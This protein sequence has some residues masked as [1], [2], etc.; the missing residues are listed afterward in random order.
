MGQSYRV[1]IGNSVSNGRTVFRLSLDNKPVFSK[2]TEHS[3]WQNPFVN[4]VSTKIYRQQKRICWVGDYAENIE[5]LMADHQ[6]PIYVSH[7]PDY[8]EVWGETVTPRSVHSKQISLDDKFLWNHDTK[9]YIDLNEYKAASVD[10]SGWILHPLPLLTSVGNSLDKDFNE[11]NIGYENIG[12]W[13]WNLLSINDKS[14]KT[15][16]KSALSSKMCN[17]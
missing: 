5:D 15:F 10:N 12:H 6:F 11:R 8:Y 17:V 2:L 4:S 9:Q 7:L 3:W 14:P 16:E 1:I 13:A